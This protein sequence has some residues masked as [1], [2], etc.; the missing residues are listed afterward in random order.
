MEESNRGFNF[1]DK[2]RLVLGFGNKDFPFLLKLYAS[3]ID[4]TLGINYNDFTSFTLFHFE[5]F[6]F[7]PDN[8]I[9]VVLVRGL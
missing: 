6:L 2:H 8:V 3:H 7:S 5:F 1:I 9:E 4:L